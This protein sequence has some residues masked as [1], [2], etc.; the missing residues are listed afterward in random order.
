MSASQTEPVTES[1]ASLL[2]RI[3]EDSRLTIAALAVMIVLGLVAASLHWVGLVLGGIL[4]GIVSKTQVRALGA[5]IVFV[6][7]VFVLFAILNGGDVTAV[8][9]WCRCRT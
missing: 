5:A 1:S 6:G 2:E 4:V 7:A 9:G 3:Y 8:P